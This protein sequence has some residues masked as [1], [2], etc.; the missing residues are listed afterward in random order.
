MDKM[1]LA[2]HLKPLTGESDW[3]VWKR[4]IRDILDYHEGAL[5]AIDG[6]ISKPAVL[7]ESATK[8]EAAQHKTAS[9]L[10]RKANSYAKSMITSSVSDSVYQKIMDKETAHETWEALKKEFEATSQDQLFKV[11]ADFFAFVWSASND[12]STH[13]AKLRTLWND[14]NNGLKQKGLN[15]LPE[16]ILVCKVLHI[17]P[18][19]FDTFKSSWMLLAKDETKTFEELSLQLTV[20]ERNSIQSNKSESPDHEAL[21]NRPQSNRNNAVKEKQQ[22]SSSESKQSNANVCNYCHKV[23]HWV[24]NCRKWIADGRPAR[25]AGKNNHQSNSLEPEL[26]P[27]GLVSIHNE[28]LAAESKDDDWWFDN[29]ATRHVTNRLDWFSSFKKFEKSHSIK[30]AGEERLS[31]VGCGQIEAISTVNGCSR[32][33]QIKDVWY[34]PQ[35]VRNLFSPLAAHDRHPTS[36]FEST[37]TSCRLLVNG[38]VV[39][40]GVRERNGSLF[41]AQMKVIS[42]ESAQSVNAVDSCGLLQ[43]YH[44]RWGHQ[45]K[46]H[47]KNKLEKELDVKVQL[48]NQMCKP[49]VYGKAHRL[50]FGTRKKGTET[51][52]PNFCGCLWSFLPLLSTKTVL[53]CIQRCLH[54]VSVQFHHQAE[55]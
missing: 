22:K 18:S 45:D 20:F 54:K 17:L 2:K 15:T 49:C 5:D 1:D 11:C 25:N 3:P 48:N 12:V 32:R 9:D 51:R 44:E 27:I 13:V 46:R 43:L 4:K 36:K 52:R 41:K 10:Y 38:S 40:S 19:C 7:K 33:V 23:G 29:G 42:P 50:P 34:V 26:D 14:L 31:A 21:Y 53:G 39:L 35:I 8:E 37:A 28:V 55:I 47:V 30:A 16:L 6:R 24:R